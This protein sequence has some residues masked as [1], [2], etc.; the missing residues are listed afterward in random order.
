MKILWITN[1]LLP[2]IV[3]HLGLNKNASG[4]W[5]GAAANNLLKY[6]NEIE[7]YIATP[8][9][10]KK[11]I[12]GKVNGI[13]FYALPYKCGDKN[14]TKQIEIWKKI[15]D[16]VKPDLVHIHGTEFNHG[17]SYINACG[18]ENVVISIQG[19]ISVIDRYALGG[20]TKKEILKNLTLHELKT[21]KLLCMHKHNK[22]R[23]IN[24]KAYF[25]SVKYVI[26]RTL[27]DKT[28][29][30][31]IN[32]NIRYFHCE[33]SLRQAFYT[34]KWNYD[35]CVK[36]SIFFSQATTPLKGFHILLKAMPIILREFP[37]TTI[38]VAG[39]NI[40]STIGLKQETYSKYIKSIIKK[41]NLE[42][43]INFTGVLNETEIIN[44]YINA[45][46]FVC[47]SSIENSSNSICEAQAL[48]MPCIA[49]YVG[50]TP[51]IVEDGVTGV[52]YRY[53]EHEML[54]HHIIEI[55]KRKELAM[56]LGKNA[57]RIAHS[58][59]DIEK[60]AKTTID[61][62]KQVIMNKN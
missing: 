4:S 8:I 33:E 30:T 5:L 57:Q 39:R 34:N 55:F 60:N 37:D 59:H 14:I 31:Q 35:E 13:S 49:S 32:P 54:A 36:H 50:G 53:E 61:I 51:S 18:N 38:R 46:L 62:Y 9:N 12:E 28:H 2:E 42:D 47:A 19:L 23:G 17:L 52:L 10:C 56:T 11:I 1:V 7:L 44:E 15:H 6:C 29:V 22:E 20:I 26:G 3:Q 27:W 25:N 16:K 43:C 21:G 24:E 41:H 40:F 48:G 45:N 58:R